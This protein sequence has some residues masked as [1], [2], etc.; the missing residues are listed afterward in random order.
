MNP[1]VQNYTHNSRRWGHHAPVT[2]TDSL[3]PIQSSH[4]NRY[5]FYYKLKL[6]FEHQI[7]SFKVSSQKKWFWYDW[8]SLNDSRHREGG[9]GRAGDA[10]PPPPPPEYNSRHR[11]ASDNRRPLTT[12][13]YDSWHY[14]NNT[15]YKIY[16]Y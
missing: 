5:P 7:A 10:R 1:R 15:F 2:L 14:F 13:W 4:Y 11:A 9:E 12:L 8:S 16:I 6:W 3:I